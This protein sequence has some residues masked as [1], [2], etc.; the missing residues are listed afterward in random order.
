MRTKIYSS[1]SSKQYTS[2]HGLTNICV[3]TGRWKNE[4]GV[5]KQNGVMLFHGRAYDNISRKFAAEL[6]RQ[7][8]RDSKLK[9]GA[10]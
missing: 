8:R 1:Y 5:D 2:E 10:K 6:L 3:L 7:F 9:G 4:N